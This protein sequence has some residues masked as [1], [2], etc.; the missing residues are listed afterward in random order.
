MVFQAGPTRFAVDLRQRRLGDGETVGRKPP[1]PGAELRPLV[2]D[3][4]KARPALYE[5]VGDDLDRP[6]LRLSGGTASGLWHSPAR[7][8]TGARRLLLDG[9]RPCTSWTD[10]HGEKRSEQMDSASCVASGGGRSYAQTLEQAPS[11]G[12]QG[13][14]M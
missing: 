2:I 5:E 6:E 11:R 12:R 10:L 7:F 4:L 3:A 1:G 14:L 13:R 8:R 9:T